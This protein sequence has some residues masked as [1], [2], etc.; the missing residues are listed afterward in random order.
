MQSHGQ[1]TQ[2]TKPGQHVTLAVEAALVRSKELR[3]MKPPFLVLDGL[4]LEP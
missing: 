3:D 4:V 1:G 2:L